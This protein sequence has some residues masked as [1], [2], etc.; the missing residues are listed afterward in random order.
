MGTAGRH[1]TLINQIFALRANLSTSFQAGFFRKVASA[2]QQ[3]AVL[4]SVTGEL[5]LTRSLG[6]LPADPRKK[7]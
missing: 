2:P 1:R 3:G 4:I 7:P 5:K 6:A